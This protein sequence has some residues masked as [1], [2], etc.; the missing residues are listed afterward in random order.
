[1]TRASFT[2]TY[3]TKTTFSTHMTKG[4]RTIDRELQG[5]V[6]GL[7]R[8]TTAEMSEALMIQPLSGEYMIDRKGMEVTEMV[9]ETG[10]YSSGRVN[11]RDY[12]YKSEVT[13][14]LKGHNRPF[15]YEREQHVITTKDVE[16][17]QIDLNSGEFEITIES[18]TMTTIEEYKE[19]NQDLD[20]DITGMTEVNSTI[21]K[22]GSNETG[23]F[24]LDV[25]TTIKTV[26]HKR[27]EEIHERT[28][29]QTVNSETKFTQDEQRQL[30]RWNVSYRRWDVRGG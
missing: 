15:E 5:Q 1:M 20:A 14:K 2:W 16:D 17:G 29:D 22:T 21:E 30:A 25:E 24:Q 7:L 27:H 18:N 10:N 11:D 13:E 19:K 4:Q 28:I 23:A 12:H 9:K 6:D 26:D 3:D 8:Q